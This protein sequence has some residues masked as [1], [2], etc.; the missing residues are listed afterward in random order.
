MSIAC[1]HCEHDNYDAKA[2]SCEV[3]WTN[4]QS[5]DHPE[6]RCSVCGQVFW[7]DTVETV[8]WETF[9]DEA[10]YENR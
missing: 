1:P 4:E 6:M 2:D 5:T 8:R 3:P 7:V 9:P 10:A